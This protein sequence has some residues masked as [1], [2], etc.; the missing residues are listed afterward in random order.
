MCYISNP[1]LPLDARPP[2]ARA[3]P[4]ALAL[5]TATVLV[6]CFELGRLPPVRWSVIGL[7]GLFAV[8]MWKVRLSTLSLLARIG[9]ALYVLPFLVTLRY[10]FEDHV[11]WWPT[12]WSLDYQDAPRSI[13]IMLAL[14]L[15][16]LVGLVT[17]LLLAGGARWPREQPDRLPVLGMTRYLIGLGLAFG[18][19]W[20]STPSETILMARY[21]LDQ[22]AAAASTARFDAASLVAYILLCVLLVDAD[23]DVARPDRRAAKLVFLLAVSGYIIVFHQLLRGDRECAGL[24][25]AMLAYALTSVRATGRERLRVLRRRLVAVWAAGTLIVTV[26]VGLTV[27]RMTL[28]DRSLLAP[29]TLL[30]GA[31]NSTWT[32]VL[33]TDLSLAD[34]FRRGEMVVEGGRTYLDYLLS[35][36]PGFLAD[37]VG[38]KRPLEASRGPSFLFMDISSGGCHLPLVPFLNFRWIGVL[39]VLTLN[40]WMLGRM[41]RWAD[42]RGRAQRFAYIATFTFLPFWFWYGDM[43]VIRGAMGILLCW[44]AYRVAGALGLRGLGQE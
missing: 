15:L 28:G 27:T 35:L 22:S 39:L 29:Q 6:F 9:L 5:S 20:L 1:V 42:H 38:W 12:P 23:S 8:A 40:G 21:G 34:R 44:W 17:G 4:L 14:G 19:S 7:F 37:A 24:V 30:E 36:P 33:L 26:F 18:L 32:A 16:G 13:E 3:L 2:L 41:E 25:A 11:H 31:T 43:Y 10:L